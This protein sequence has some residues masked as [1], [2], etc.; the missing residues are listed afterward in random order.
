MLLNK[1]FLYFHTVKYLKFRQIFHRLL[2]NLPI[3][4][5]V[6]NLHIELR[7]HKHKCFSWLKK[8]DFFIPPDEFHLINETGK[9]SIVGWEGD[10]K[11]KLWRYNQHYFNWLLSHTNKVEYSKLENPAPALIEEWINY[12]HIG[13]GVGWEPYPTSIR[14]VNWIKSSMSGANFSEK[15]IS[16]LY[17][18]S[19]YLNRNIE[20]HLMGNHI[21]A[22][23]KALI[24]SGLFFEGKEAN[25]WLIKGIDILNDQIDE[26]ILNDG[27]H[28]EL[29]TMYHSIILEDFLDIINLMHV[30]DIHTTRYLN[31]KLIEKIPI[32]L[33]WLETM[34]L[35]D[36]DITFS[37]DSSFKI[38]SKPEALITY[39]K[40][41]G[42]IS[43]KTSIS[44]VIDGFKHLSESG[45]IRHKGPNHVAIINVADIAPDYQPGHAHAD[46]MS[47]ELSVFNKRLFVNSGTSCYE[48][49]PLRDYQ[50][51]TRAHNTVEINN[52]NSS[53]VW[54]GFR[55][56]K[57][58]KITK[59]S[60]LNDLNK[61]ICSHDGYTKLKGRPIHSRQWSFSENILDIEDT[62]DGPYIEASAFYHLHPE[63]K[64]QQKKDKFI[65]SLGDKKV[66]INSLQNNIKISQGMY[67][68]QFNIGV[69]NH[70]LK[71]QIINGKSN[72]RISWN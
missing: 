30:Y 39:A 55:V 17:I 69:S 25:K 19:R 13:S 56:G 38:A 33:N 51:S 62:I 48:T 18:Q 42:L 70:F 36:G 14:I 10:D 1:F 68:P 41:L 64:V 50:R 45:F 40:K 61:V 58:A 32:M 71:V 49:G 72:L 6:N 24:F 2:K 60:I 23:A 9:L 35:P 54:G 16:N 22:N 20:W 47:F 43:N 27:A 12:Q 29:S 53:D 7:N 52:I 3:R 66:C 65:C 28:F 67:Y 46:T 21:I 4:V 8:P 44:Y 34:C 11:S 57:R 5:K 31:N 59:L 37:N 26:Q 63:W 15:A